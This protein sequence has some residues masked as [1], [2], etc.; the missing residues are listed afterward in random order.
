MGPRPDP[1]RCEK[2][3]KGKNK[4]GDSVAGEPVTNRLFRIL[5]DRNSEHM[6]SVDYVFLGPSQNPTPIPS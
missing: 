2:Q 4:G 1:D 5:P 6:V 3:N